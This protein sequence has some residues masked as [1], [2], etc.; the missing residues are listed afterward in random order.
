[1]TNRR[2]VLVGF[3]G[4]G[5]TS[6]AKALAHQLD[7]DFVDLDTFIIETHGRSP[8]EIIE[9]D[10][11][12]AFRLIETRALEEVLKTAEFRLIA[13]GGGTW[14][15][16]ANRTLIGAHDCLSVWLDAPF[17]LCWQRI[18]AAENANRP[19]APDR[20]TAQKLYQSRRADYYLAQLRI[21]A[22]AGKELA[23]I[24]D[25]ISRNA[26]AN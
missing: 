17:D 25:E 15:I 9:E 12:P 24:M 13:L 20:E 7:C 18:S 11:E 1:M 6:V 5:K 26:S 23:D 4:C 16:P 2:I 22:N 14:T 3:M 8:A 19:L 10:G 21:D